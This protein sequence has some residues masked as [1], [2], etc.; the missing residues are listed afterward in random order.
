MSEKKHWQDILFF[1]LKDDLT[2]ETIPSAPKSPEKFTVV[3]KRN[4]SQSMIYSCFPH[5]FR[6][7][8]KNCQCCQNFNCIEVESCQFQSGN[9]LL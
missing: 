2:L 6:T 7:L 8:W 4:I 1:R 9:I 5:Y 3:Q